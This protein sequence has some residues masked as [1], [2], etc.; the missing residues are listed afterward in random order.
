MTLPPFIPDD[1][2]SSRAGYA[3]ERIAFKRQ[4]GGSVFGLFQPGLLLSR[5]TVAEFC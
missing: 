1:E 5:S 4:I 3:K 2:A